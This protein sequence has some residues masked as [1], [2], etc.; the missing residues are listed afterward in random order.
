MNKILSSKIDSSS[1][2]NRRKMVSI[3]KPSAILLNQSHK[4]HQSSHYEKTETS[5][6]ETEE[7]ARKLNLAAP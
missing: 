4:H 2:I 3:A 5:T 7:S 6:Y 1:A